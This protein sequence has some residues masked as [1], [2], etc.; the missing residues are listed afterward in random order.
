MPL[1]MSHKEADYS[2]LSSFGKSVFD[3]SN[4]TKQFITMEAVNRHVV[5]KET[6]A[7]SFGTVN[8]IPAFTTRNTGER[9]TAEEFWNAYVADIEKNWN[10]W[11]QNIK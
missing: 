10:E 9:K 4:N 6:N 2:S 8:V 7:R 5:Y 3:I 1:N 11:L